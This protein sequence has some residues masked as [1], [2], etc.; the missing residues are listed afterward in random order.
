MPAEKNNSCS[1]SREP[2]RMKRQVLFLVRVKKP[3]DN[4]GFPSTYVWWAAS[5][6][7]QEDKNK[8]G[9]MD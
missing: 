2:D 9:K 7:C 6:G 1:Y 4:G 3:L 8:W 5:G